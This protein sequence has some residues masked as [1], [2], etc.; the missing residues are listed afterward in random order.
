MVVKIRT[1]GPTCIRRGC[2]S[3]A[4]IAY[5]GDRYPLYCSFACHD[6]DVAAN[7]GTP[8][9]EQWERYRHR[10]ATLGRADVDVT[11]L[12]RRA[13]MRRRRVERMLAEV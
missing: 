1:D 9:E 4:R 12:R 11:E 5:H 6:A 3:K 7:A 10:V 13:Q 8:R 2:T